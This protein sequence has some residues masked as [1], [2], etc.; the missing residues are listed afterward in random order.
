MDKSSSSDDVLGGVAVDANAAIDDD[1]VDGD[2]QSAFLCQYELQQQERRR[3]QSQSMTYPSEESAD[4]Y[5]SGANHSG[6]PGIPGSANERDIIAR[7]MRTMLNI[8]SPREFQMRAIYHGAFEENLLIYLISKTGSGKS[9][10][11]EAINVLRRGVAV[12]LVP[13]IAL[14]SDQVTKA[15]KI[16]INN[17]AY[18]I[19]EHK[20]NDLALLKERL[21][22]AS[23]EELDHVSINLFMS[24]TA[25]CAGSEWPAIL[26]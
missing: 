12:T 5:Q 23:A 11:P 18:H 19:D 2:T 25:L 1:E 15:F 3:S 7:T 13:L 24:P 17:E 26:N 22:K 16:E 20:G 8:Q 6:I 4:L 21:V 9:A 14:G 10:V